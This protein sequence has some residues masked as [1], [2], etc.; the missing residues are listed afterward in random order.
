M[1]SDRMDWDKLRVF[2]VVA[3]LE[4]M[5]AAA[6]RLGESTPTVSRKIDELEESL[7]SKLFVRS[8]RGM[9]LTDAGKKALRYASQMEEAANQVVQEAGSQSEQLEGK[10][11]LVTGDG[12]GPYWVARHLGEF[13]KMHP[14]IKLRM[15]TQEGPPDFENENVDVAIQFVEP[16]DPEVI[17]RKLGTVHYIGFAAQSYLDKQENM[18]SSLFEYY[19]HRCILHE[20]YVNQIERWAPKM[21][22]LKKMIDFAFVTN[23]ASAMI[24]FCHRGGGIA[25]LPTYI[26]EVFPDLEA[27]DMAEVAPIHFWLTYTEEARRKAEGHAVIEWIKTLFD[28]SRSQWFRDSFIHPKEVWT[29]SKASNISRI[30]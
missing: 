12:L 16:R 4:S 7:Q 29:D 15:R 20:A 1:P 22:E 14:R 6:K 19:H 30:A 5:T 9:V 23:S 27:L 11:T 26:K 10:I 28:Q 24:E 17:A 18:P 2:K 3:E 21:A 8:T 25:L 13:Q